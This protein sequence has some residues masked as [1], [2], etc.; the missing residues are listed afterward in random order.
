MFKEDVDFKNKPKMLSLALNDYEVGKDAQLDEYLQDFTIIKLIDD[1]YPIKP[2][3]G[4]EN[5]Q[6][7][8]KVK[9]NAEAI[10][11]DEIVKELLFSLHGE[12]NK[13]DTV[14]KINIK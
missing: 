12:F 6:G 1:E 14:K 5:L 13:P 9:L 11:D 10:N 7:T 4:K 3:R 2:K 8:G